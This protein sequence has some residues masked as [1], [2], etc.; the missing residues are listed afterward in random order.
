VNAE[1]HDGR[2]DMGVAADIASGLPRTHACRM[3]VLEEG[4]MI[5][6]GE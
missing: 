1:V 3:M 6:G 4:K 2:D 5:R